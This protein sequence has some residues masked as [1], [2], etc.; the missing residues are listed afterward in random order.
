MAP[1]SRRIK[2]E[3]CGAALQADGESSMVTCQYCGA[4]NVVA[5]V[6]TVADLSGYPLDQLAQSTDWEHRQLAARNPACVLPL[7]TAMIG[8]FAD[9]RLAMRLNLRGLPNDSM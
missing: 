6:P 3:G 7:F 1:M 8:F 2:C 9:T 4:T 5:V